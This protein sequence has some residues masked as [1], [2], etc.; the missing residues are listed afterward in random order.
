MIIIIAIYARQSVERENSVSIETQIDFCKTCI[1]PNEKHEKLKIY[2][3]AGASGGNT[4]RPGFQRLIYDIE[5]GKISKV[6]VYKLDR[7]S[8]SLCDFVGILQNFKDHN[9]EFVSSQEAFDTS[10]VYGTLILNILMVFAEFERTSIINRVRDA[11]DKRT[12]MGLYMGGR[13]QYGFTLEDAILNGIKTKIYVPIPEEIEH[14]QYIFEMYAQEQVSLRM[15]LD[16][17]LANNIK[18]ASGEDWT[19]AKLSTLLKNPVYVK[20]D[21]DVY[22]Y[23][24]GH[25]VR[26]VNDV[27]AFDGSKAVLLFGKT[28]HDK[29]L[30]DWSDMKLVLTQHTGVVPSDIWLKCQ[31]KIEKNKQIGNSLSNKTSWLGG[32]IVCSKCGHT[33]TT[34]CGETRKYFVCTGRTHKKTCSGI[35]GSVYVEDMERLVDG[36]ILEKLKTLKATRKEISEVHLAEM[37]ECKLKLASIQQQE[38]SLGEKLMRGD[39][40]DDLV[41]IANKKASELKQE[42]LRLT[43]QLEQL[44]YQD[45][46]V[47]TVIDLSKKWSK[48]DF[49]EKKAVANVLLRKIVLYEDGTPELIWNI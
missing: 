6:I 3:D 46:E 36:S 40:N 26:I 14:I 27:S 44:R 37:N 41:Q 2:K 20:A 11:Y 28:K 30:P 31:R 33:M 17:L 18:P 22:E 25:N 34:K 43:E 1:K 13:R 48:A 7:M 32:L 19:T 12:D 10:S 29:T 15:L 5:R 39:F 21:S 47:K 4:N 16:N 23:F 38:K 35:K 45:R 24:N 8:R 9:V 42:K 49:R